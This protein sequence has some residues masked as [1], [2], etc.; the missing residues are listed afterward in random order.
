MPDRTHKVEL[1]Q[2]DPIQHRLSHGDRGVSLGM[3]G[4][5]AISQHAVTQGQGKMLIKVI[6]VPVQGHVVALGLVGIH[7]HSQQ[8]HEHG[9]CRRADQVGGGT[10]T[11]LRLDLT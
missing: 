8:V 1:T 4:L 2:A 6:E 7:A 3:A 11:L 10:G 5:L 9:R